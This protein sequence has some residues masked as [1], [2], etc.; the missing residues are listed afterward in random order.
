MKGKYLKKWTAVFLSTA[1]SISIISGC[2]NSDKEPTDSTDKSANETTDTANKDTASDEASDVQDGDTPL[3]GSWIDLSYGIQMK[4]EKD[5]TFVVWNDEQTAKGTYTYENNYLVMT[6]KDVQNEEKGYV[7]FSD[8]HFALFTSD[9][10]IVDYTTDCFV[11][12]SAADKYDPAKDFSRYNQAWTITSGPDQ[13]IINNETYAANELYIIL[14]KGNRLRIGKPEKIGDPNY[15]VLTEGVIE[16]SNNY[17]KL[18]FIFSD[19]FTG[20]DGTDYR[21]ELKYGQWIISPEGDISGN[22]QLVLSP[23]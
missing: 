10:M 13:F 19:P 8:D 5:G 1:L 14:T 16:F 20:Q 6:S 3:I 7:K 4:I 21:S 23:L 11:R 18:E 15:D 17:S 9:S 12:S 22:P 2:G